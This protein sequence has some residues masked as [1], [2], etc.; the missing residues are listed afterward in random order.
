MY[1]C[2]IGPHG[3]GKTTLGKALCHE[4]GAVYREELGRVL[5]DEALAQDQDATAL[6][7]D[8]DFDHRVIEGDLQRDLTPW[9]ERCVLETWH[10]GNFG[11]AWVRSPEVATRFEA[12]ARSRARALSAR[13][14][15]VQP[16]TARREVLRAR[17]GEPGGTEDERLDF[18]GL[19][20]NEGV[21][22]A[23]AWGLRVL[24]AIDTSDD[25]AEV[26]ARRIVKQAA[27]QLVQH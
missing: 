6:R 14:L 7:F 25:G 10:P 12:L 8:S 1:I 20:A 21:R 26:I 9:P 5:R 27:T 16:L 3:V 22:V 11:Y 15:V 13:G 17:L 18:F 24:P 19:V 4:A 2:L 23:R